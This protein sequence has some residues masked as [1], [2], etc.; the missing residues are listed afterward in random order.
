MWLYTPKACFELLYETSCLYTLPSC[1]WKCTQQ[2]LVVQ[3]S[4][5]TSLQRA[6]CLPQAQQQV[7]LHSACD[8]GD[9][10]AA[11]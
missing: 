6:V 9:A 4:G 8:G 7:H 3:L 10:Y 2:C 11:E 5:W 1:T